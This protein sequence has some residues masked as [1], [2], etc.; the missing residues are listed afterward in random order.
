MYKSNVG[1][2]PLRVYPCKYWWVRYA[3]ACT[4]FSDLHDKMLNAYIKYK[5][6]PEDYA[7]QGAWDK[8]RIWI[9]KDRQQIELDPESEEYKAYLEITRINDNF[10]EQRKGVTWVDCP[11]QEEDQSACPF[12]EPEPNYK[13]IPLEELRERKGYDISEY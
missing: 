6:L 3:V 5:G 12:Y 10:D 7:Y 11:F 2:F 1:D 9:Y 8:R 4:Y 13:D